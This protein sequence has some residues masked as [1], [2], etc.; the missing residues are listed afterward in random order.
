MPKLIG[1]ESSQAAPS[2]SNRG[3]QDPEGYGKAAGAFGEALGEGV[4]RVADT[5]LTRHK[6]NE[7]AHI[8]AE[9]SK[10]NAELT[11][12]MEEAFRTADPNDPTVGKKF[13]EETLMPALDKIGELPETRDGRMLYDRLRAG[14]EANYAVNAAAKQANLQGV[15]AVNNFLTARSLNVSSTRANPGLMETNSLL[16]A[17]SIPNTIDPEV[18]MKLLRDALGE[19]AGAAVMGLS[20]KGD[21][22]G[23]REL[24]NSGKLDAFV[25]ASAK[26]QLENG[27]RTDENAA[28]ADEDRAT[29]L[30]DKAKEQKFSLIESDLLNKLVDPVT[31][32]VRLDSTTWNKD[33]TEQLR[34]EPDRIKS[35]IAIGRSL[36]DPDEN[37][38]TI[39]QDLWDRARLPRG[40]ANRPSRTEIGAAVGRG[41]NLPSYNAIIQRLDGH[42]N[43]ERMAED[44][45]VTK[46]LAA[47]KDQ[48][49]TQED[50]TVPDPDGE[51]NYTNFVTWFWNE[52]NKQRDGG[53]AYTDLLAAGGKNYMGNSIASFYRNKGEIKRSVRAF[54]RGE[55]PPSRSAHRD[56]SSTLSA[57]QRV[58]GAPSKR[59]PAEL[60]KLLQGEEPTKPVNETADMSA[61][62]D[63]IT[64][65]E[66]KR[67]EKYL[68]DARE[69]AA[70]TEFGPG[71]PGGTD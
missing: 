67:F 65:E 3:Y 25:D 14:L 6:E 20:S 22:A 66:K 35:L 12:K 52:Y 63:D 54:R 21:F 32:V 23:A 38:A 9:M 5:L 45:S 47:A 60:D 48:L 44:D 50:R 30:A 11:V 56:R 27:I 62:P 51:L 68:K 19:N 39:F 43:P 59:S 13:H 70:K 15:A 46:F 34:G 69:E 53:I 55:T 28:Q 57:T 37:N 42:G 71:A 40:D 49:A 26:E 41:I 24:L 17:S 36:L 61:V 33:V 58:E 4:M 2:P 16:I 8:A 10:V 1:Y 31:G 18:R 7:A 64:P 29:R